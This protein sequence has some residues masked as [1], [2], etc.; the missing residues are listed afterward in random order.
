MHN[1]RS[2][3]APRV[4]GSTE[5]HESN[6]PL[7]KSKLVARNPLVDHITSEGVVSHFQRRSGILYFN[8]S[9]NSRLTEE[10]QNREV[11]QLQNALEVLINPVSTSANS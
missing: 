3:L 4:S 7:P 9:I 8:S 5:T 1:L 10:I 6:F 11:L 2:Y